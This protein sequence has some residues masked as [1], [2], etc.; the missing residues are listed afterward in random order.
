MRVGVEACTWAN[1]RGYGRFTRELVSAMVS[2]YPQ[3]RFV[4]VVDTHTAR[5]CTFP[6]GA[7]A[8]VVNTVAQPTK[9]AAADGSRSLQDL[10]RMSRALATARFDVVLFPT[11]YT[12]VP[13]PG[14]TPVVLTIHDATDVKQP[15]LLFPSWRSRLL[16]RIKS[17]LAIRR[18][19]RIVT[20]SNDARRQIA[21]A[22]GLHEASISVIS[23]GH[24]PG[25]HPRPGDPAVE[26]VRDRY[27]LPR[28][29]SLILYV[30]GI[31]PH[32]NLAALLR[33]AA[34]VRKEEPS[35]WHVVLVGDYQ[36]DSFLG[37]YQELVALVRSLALEPHVTFAGF[38]PDGDLALLYNA[39]TMLV[40][41]SKGEGFG[42]PV[43]EA[44]ACGLPVI[45][46]DRNSLPEVLGGAG[47]L[48]DPDSDDALAA[49][50]LRLLREPDLRTEL[51]ARGLVR[52]GAYT[53]SAGAETMVRVLEDAAGKR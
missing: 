38:V 5:E 11:R 49:C 48:F 18:A 22:F 41:P 19:D 51:R 29:A 35:G 2:R 46:S 26:Q 50:I 30:G 3:H 27:R 47:V 39:A 4:L 20:V 28:N 13:L 44:M 10:W 15:R 12:F 32:K 6:A 9:A 43:V 16:W 37:C 33:A 42:L 21:A 8:V 31:S 23:E 52:A 40:L 7:E 25:F 1:R 45:A 36:G 17:Q 53:W 14:R 24:D 34:I